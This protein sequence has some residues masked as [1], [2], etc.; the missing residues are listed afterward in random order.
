MNK[1]P[2]LITVVIY[3]AVQQ[4]REKKANLLTYRTFELEYFAIT[5]HYDQSFMLIS[6]EP[7][8]AILSI[9]FESRFSKFGI[10]QTCM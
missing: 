2:F 7:H 10:V 4:R 9:Y 3:D 6:N 8:K 1:I 5:M